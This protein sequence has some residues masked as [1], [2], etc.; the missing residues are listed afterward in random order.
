MEG[1]VPQGV[2]KAA[3]SLQEIV[4]RHAGNN[5]FVGNTATAVSFRANDNQ[6]VAGAPAVGNIWNANTQG[7]D[8]SGLYTTGL[9]IRSGDPHANGKNF[10]L[11]TNG[12][13]TF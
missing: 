9:T 6:T 8:S 7:T 1:I 5:N 13:I 11:G 4:V 3:C 2:T 12:V 10:G